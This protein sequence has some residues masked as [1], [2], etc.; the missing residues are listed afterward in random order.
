M[1][2][3]FGLM[4]KVRIRPAKAYPVH[5][6]SQFIQIIFFLR[7]DVAHLQNQ[8]LPQD[9]VGLSRSHTVLISV[10]SVSG[11][12]SEPSGL[13]SSPLSGKTPIT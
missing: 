9:G 2:T 8:L 6:P 5:T 3:G 7:L 11:K 13:G 10:F 4:S 12:I 1:K